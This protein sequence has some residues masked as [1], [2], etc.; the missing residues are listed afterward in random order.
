MDTV[1]EAKS[2]HSKPSEV[3]TESVEPEL[4]E[5]ETMEPDT[6]ETEAPETETT[7]DKVETTVNESKQQKLRRNDDSNYHPNDKR[8]N[9]KLTET[10]P[11]AAAL[12]H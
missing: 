7:A 3:E 12:N 1:N 6:S 11:H 4:T 8:V 9:Y 10:N 5:S 2:Q